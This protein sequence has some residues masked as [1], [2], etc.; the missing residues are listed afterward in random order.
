MSTIYRVLTQYRVSV[1]TPGGTYWHTAAVHYVGTDPE[2]AQTTYRAER[3]RDYG[4]AGRLG[5]PAR[6]TVL[7]MLD[8]AD[9]DGAGGP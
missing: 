6:L 5:S 7:E 3:R 1:Q 4:G 2:A 8:S 9:L